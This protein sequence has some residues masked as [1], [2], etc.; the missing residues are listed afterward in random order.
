MGGVWGGGEAPTRKKWGGSGGGAKP[1]L[2][3]SCQA[4]PPGMFLPNPTPSGMLAGH[5]IE[6]VTDWAVRNYRLH[7]IYRLVWE[8]PQLKMGGVW[9]G[10]SPPAPPATWGCPIY[11]FIDLELLHSKQGGGGVS[12]TLP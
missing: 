4:A 10:R 5:S 3:H 1:P 2:A 12:G 11:L 9:G 6:S 7:L 8:P